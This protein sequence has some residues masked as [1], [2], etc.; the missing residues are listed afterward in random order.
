MKKITIVIPTFNERRNVNDLSH[1]L[2]DSLEQAGLQ[3]ELLFVDD[4]SNDGTPE[5]LNS[6]TN[7]FPIKVLSKQGKKG[8]AFSLLEGFQKADGE[9]IAMIDA[10]QQYPPESIPEMVKKLDEFDIVV[11]NRKNRH[12]STTRNYLS[13][14]YTFI[15]GKMLLGLSVD[16]QSG[17]KVFNKQV[18]HNLRLNP[19]PWGFDYEFLYKA[20]RMRWQIGQVDTVFNERL[21]GTSNVNYMLTGLELA[22]GAIKL[23]LE[24]FVKD[25]LR[26]LDHPH[27]SEKHPVHFNNPVDFLFV[28]EIFSAKKHLYLETISLLVFVSLFVISLV[29]IFNI[30]FS[31][32]I[33]IIVSGVISLFY[34]GL[35]LFKLIIV[36]QSLK[37]PLISFAKKEISA[38]KNEDLPIYTLLIPLYKEA[39]VIPQIIK[40]MTAIDY[41]HDK[42]D[43]IITLEE[44]DHETINAIKKANPPEYFKTLILPDVTPKTKPKALNVAFPQTKGEFVVIY[45][46]EII[47]DPDQLKKAYLAFRKYPD[48]GCFQTR[49]DHYNANQNVVTKL[50]NTEFSFYYDLFLPGLQKMGYP[51]PLSGHSTHFRRS[52]LEKIGAWDPYNV[53]ED[54]DVGIRLH[55]MG[56]KTD[57]IDSTSK[58]EATSGLNAWINQRTRWMKGFIQ[59]SIVHLRHPLRFKEEIGGWRNFIAFLFTV[60]GT[61][62]VNILNL[63]YWLFLIGWFST[64]SIFIQKLFPAPILYISVVSFIVG[65]SIFTYLNLIGAYKRERHALVKYSLLSP[66]YW[67]LL[68]FA[69]IKALIEIFVKPH[70]WDKTRH[71]GHL[72]NIKY[73][74]N[75]N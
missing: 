43:I 35:M 73:A 31:V 49:L 72:T 30:A 62:V 4:H 53:T 26:F 14:L 69:T 19:T 61:V 10:D 46:A 2:V 45:D 38:I 68:T 6:L 41:P 8:K 1:R 11:A 56:F 60:P 15:F 71:G 42:L 3:Y 20:K 17:L 57:I 24:Y 40:A 54:C 70:H 25:I 63:F 66:L 13:Q 74:T 39:E 16:V 52:V 22:Y 47:P 18:M 9:V 23:R 28:P 67:V 75:T 59:T 65:N 21:Y 29:W 12:V 44:Y 37:R 50:F 5:Y 33:L 34:L 64:H 7:Q 58:E 32:P 55:R 27:H 51:V 48:I 36:S